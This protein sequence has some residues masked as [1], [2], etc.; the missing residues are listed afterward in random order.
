[1]ALDKQSLENKIKALLSLD[2]P[3]NAATGE[4]CANK[5]ADYVDEYLADIEL[6]PFPAPGIQ[7]GAPPVP[8]PTGPGQKVEPTAP[9][10]AGQFRG[11]LV[12]I[13]SAPLAPGIFEPACGVAFVADMAL[14]I[15]VSDSNEYAA[16]GASLLSA[17]PNIDIAFNK[18]KEGLSHEEVAKEIANQIHAATTATIFT[19]AG[20]YAK[21]AFV[22]TPPAPLYTSPFK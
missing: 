20:P 8:D 1:M 4:D 10:V 15:A 7:P 12:G 19:A 5:I 16:A 6:D 11:A 17:P 9:L 21:A 2:S 14:M 13:M 22:Q 18:C 3:P